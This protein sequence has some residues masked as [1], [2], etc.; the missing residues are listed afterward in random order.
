MT[1][2]KSIIA[3][4]C[5]HILD[6]AVITTTSHYLFHH[7]DL[8]QNNAE[9]IIFFKMYKNTEDNNAEQKLLDRCIDTSMLNKMTDHHLIIST[10]IKH[11]L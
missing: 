6:T 2:Q 10:K 7:K 11:T 3:I 1:Q 4:T 5:F 9:R 8:T